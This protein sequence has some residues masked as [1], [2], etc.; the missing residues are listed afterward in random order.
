[1]QSRVTP[2][3]FTVYKALI[4]EQATPE[5]LGQTYG[6]AANAIYAVKHRC[7]KM[8]IAEAQQLRAEWE[9]FRERPTRSI[10]A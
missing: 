4:E 5:E 2:E 10:N 9:Q 6:K 7:E 8:L 1:V 3:N